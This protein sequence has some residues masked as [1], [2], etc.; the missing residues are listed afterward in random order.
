MHV[1]TQLPALHTSTIL[2]GV[3]LKELTHRVHLN[4]CITQGMSVTR[5]CMFSRYH[6][7]S[8]TNDT[9]VPS[10]ALSLVNKPLCI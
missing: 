6:W 10:T 5:L 9:A 1:E 2:Q 3:Q 4:V 8:L 7:S